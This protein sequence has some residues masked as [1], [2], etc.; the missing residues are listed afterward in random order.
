MRD[1]VISQ[2]D[3]QAAS[4]N[5]RAGKALRIAALGLLPL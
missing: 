3:R 5:I 1:A 4:F 2:N